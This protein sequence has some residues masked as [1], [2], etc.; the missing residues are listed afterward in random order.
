MIAVRLLHVS[1]SA[2][3][4]SQASKL[5]RY[6]ELNYAGTFGADLQTYTF[7]CLTKHLIRDTELHGCL[8]SH[9]IFSLEGSLGYYRRS[10]HGTNGFCHQFKKVD[11]DVM[12]MIMMHY[13]F[14]NPRL[15]KKQFIIEQHFNE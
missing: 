2:Q 3:A 4:L 6:F 7:H 12:I 14:L 11:F 13:V 10:L 1:S 8:S 15:R 9:S 5:M